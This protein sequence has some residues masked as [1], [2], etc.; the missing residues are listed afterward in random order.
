MRSRISERVVAGVA[1]AMTLAVP[2][3]GC[4]SNSTSSKSTSA[5][6]GSA[7]SAT[8]TG[9]SA[10]TSSAPVQPSDY[11]GLL[12]KASDIDAPVQFTA[13]PPTINPNG[14]PG[15][16]TM[17]QDEDGTHVI[18][19]TIQVFADPAAA[20]DALNEAKGQQ[21]EVIKDPTTQSADVGTGGTI[22]LGNAPDRSKGVTILLFTEGRA[23]VTLE[24]D[25][26]AETLAPPE[27]VNGVGQKQV[28]AIKKGLAN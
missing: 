10:E 5:T 15:A 27:F 25:G 26:P 12:I 11:T 23:F 18:K 20:T 13:S 7:T 16:A 3:A 4:G 28:E 17:F 22:L 1:L 14:Q 9:G 24:F 19:D 6:S 21:G 8:S 2:V